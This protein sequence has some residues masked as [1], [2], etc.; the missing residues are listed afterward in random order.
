[1]DIKK[2]NNWSTHND[3]YS[4]RVAEGK[5]ALAVGRPLVHSLS[6]SIGHQLQ[7]NLSIMKKSEKQQYH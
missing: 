1:M 5:D 6:D 7:Q 3:K 2:I 4:V